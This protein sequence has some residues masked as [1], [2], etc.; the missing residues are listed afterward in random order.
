MY[1][2]GL[3]ESKLGKGDCLTSKIHVEIYLLVFIKE[4]FK[5]FFLE[6]L[7]CHLQK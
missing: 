4:I 7:C 6:N 3:N 1:C 2:R 5:V